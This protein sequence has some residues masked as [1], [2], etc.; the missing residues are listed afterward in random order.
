M[1]QTVLVFDS[2]VGGLSIARCI[3]QRLPSVNLDFLADTEFFPYGDRDHEEIIAR[4]CELIARRLSDQP[5]A[6]VVVACNTASTVALPALRERLSIPVV[7][8]VPAIKPAARLS[9]TR[10]IGLLATPA[11]IRR[12]YIDQLVSEFAPHCHLTRIGDGRLVHWI[13]NWARGSELPEADL[14]AVLEPFRASQ[15]DTVVLGCTHYP[16]I[17]QTLAALLPQVLH[18]VDS[19][20]AIARRVEHLLFTEGVAT[21]QES[22][23][24]A[25]CPGSLVLSFTGQSPAS[26]QLLLS[27]AGLAVSESE[28][29]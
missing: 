6:A 13:E 23:E 1:S 21:V 10:Q 9:A 27:R 29:R 16:L 25:Q 28:A 4:C 18:W 3:R 24:P 26:L 8:V 5:A 12:P 11:T 17:A 7:G 19:G 2:G 20:E 22:D 14:S 15:V